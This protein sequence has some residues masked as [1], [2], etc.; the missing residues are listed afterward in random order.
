MRFEEKRWKEEKKTETCFVFSDQPDVAENNND[1]I[2]NGYDVAEEFR[3][4][5]R[6]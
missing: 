6:I 1:G 3:I 5:H 2:K 4:G